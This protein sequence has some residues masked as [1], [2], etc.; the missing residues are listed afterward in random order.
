[1][2]RKATFDGIGL[3]TLSNYA[4][5]TS[6]L[7]DEA[8]NKKIDSSESN[9]NEGQLNSDD[10]RETDSRLEREKDELYFK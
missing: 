4:A 1:M 7:S 10:E 5:P 8:K 2:N 9:L 6:Q 3:S